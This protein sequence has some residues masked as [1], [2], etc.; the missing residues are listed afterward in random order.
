MEIVY[1]NEVFEKFAPRVSLKNTWPFLIALFL[2]LIMI[3]VAVFV[4]QEWKYGLIVS[5]FWLLLTLAMVTNVLPLGSWY[6][7]SRSGL[8][9]KR[10]YSVRMIPL[11]GLE[12]VKILD[13]EMVE[14]EMM[15]YYNAEIGNAY[16]KMDIIAGFKSRLAMGKFIKYCLVP[17][18]FTGKQ[19]GNPIIMR[20]V[21]ANTVGEFVLVSTKEGEKYLLSPKEIA[22]FIRA[23]QAAKGV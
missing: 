6:G 19:I 17:I 8:L 14:K 2:I 16:G 11:A 13:A 10:M 23:I 7:V 3:V 1:K 4:L 20:D 18:V 12:E 15:S 22:Y 9:L 5:G 21:K